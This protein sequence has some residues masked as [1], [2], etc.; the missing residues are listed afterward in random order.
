MTRGLRNN[1]PGNIRHSSTKWQGEVEGSDTSFK[2][3]L[4]M[5]WGYRAMF[6]TLRTYKDKHNR[7][8][9]REMISRWAPPCENDTETYIKMVS[10]RAKVF[11]EIELDTYNK[12]QMCRIVEAMSYMENGVAGN[13]EEIYKGWDL[14]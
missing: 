7:K 3:F 9:L 2:T 8:T 10:N 12:N 13:F 11:S 4:S 1:N 14:I 6:K 5:T